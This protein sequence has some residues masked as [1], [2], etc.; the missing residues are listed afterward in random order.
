MKYNEASEIQDKVE[1]K[2]YEYTLNEFV[3][4]KHKKQINLIFIFII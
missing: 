3:N 1:K 2:T 4:T